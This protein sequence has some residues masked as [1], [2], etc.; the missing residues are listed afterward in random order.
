[1]HS[2]DEILLPMCDLEALCDRQTF[3]HDIQTMVNDRQTYVQ[4]RGA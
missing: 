1:M 3:A 4:L 2:L